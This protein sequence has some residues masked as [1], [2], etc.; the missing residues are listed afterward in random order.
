MRLNSVRVRLTLWN[1]AVLA[2]VLA[3]FAAALCYS[4]RA[5]LSASVDRDL[6]DR[7]HMFA[8]SWARGAAG[9][10]P[11]P[12]A[13]PGRPPSSWYVP[14]QGVPLP[15]P[16]GPEWP[17]P[18]APPAMPPAG[19]QS[20]GP[21]A[22]EWPPPADRDASRRGYFRR[23]RVLNLEG[24]PM[25][26]FSEDEPWDAD[27]FLLSAA[28]QQNYSTVI[29]DH[30]PVRVFSAPLWVNGQVEGVVQV[31]HPL[32]EQQRL[33]D[34]LLRALLTLIPLALV[35]AGAGGLFLADRSL[36]PVRN[37]TQAAAQIGA[38]DLSRR[39]EVTGQDELGE[40]AHTF[41]GMISRL[42][43]AFERL[44][45]AY[46][47]QRRFTGDASH[48]L[49]TPLTAIKANT[50]L[51]LCGERTHAEY[52]EALQ[53]A[54]QAADTMTRIVQ[55]L[56]LLARSD[57]GQLRLDQQPLP[58][59]TMLRR[60][61]ASV[62]AH[63]RAPVFLE[64]P[65]RPLGVLGDAH[66]LTRL[67]VNL[68][69]NAL[70]HTPLDGRVTLAVSAAVG[71]AGEMVV[72]RVQDTGEG[73]APEHLPHVCERFYRVDTARARSAGGTGLGLAICQS[74]IQAHRGTMRVESTVGVGTTVII[75]LPRAQ[76]AAEAD[77]S[78]AAI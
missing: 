2:L 38:E 59:E 68:L 47:Q 27:T 24:G 26:P 50:S 69:E 76:A 63:E 43:G 65:E 30:E 42:E 11:R 70:R 40:L 9:P 49:R 21:Q 3:G 37:I 60:A 57:G 61:L 33:N 19:A 12:F 14:E 39:L 28:G 71:R 10:P 29:V 16:E 6:A 31:A 52:R 56:L 20:P 17:P 46:E 55:D 41:N 35:V 13:A 62:P 75:S 5:I 78:A 34:G 54:D 23:P 64:L 1:V 22:G 66:H 72:I 45:S 25:V 18:E 44:E 58:I 73:I 53:A 8:A 77:L 7:A 48:E 74:I 36:R 51:A 32:I 67:F 15:G 4:V